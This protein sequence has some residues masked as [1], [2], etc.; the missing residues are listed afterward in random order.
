MALDAPP[1]THGVIDDHYPAL[2]KPFRFHVGECTRVDHRDADRLEQLLAGIAEHRLEY[3][4]ALGLDWNQVIRLALIDLL[5]DPAREPRQQI[6]FECSFPAP[7]R[8]AMQRWICERGAQVPHHIFRTL[9]RVCDS[10]QTAR[11]TQSW[12][13]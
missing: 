6:A 1:G 4:R 10:S 9:R 2:R 13:G 3:P 11:K 7:P 8:A 5:E 12:D